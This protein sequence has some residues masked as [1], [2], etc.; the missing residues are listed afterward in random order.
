ME[1]SVGEII[2]I[3]SSKRTRS[4]GSKLCYH[5]DF[6]PGFRSVFFTMNYRSRM[7]KCNVYKVLSYFD[8]GGL[9]FSRMMLLIPPFLSKIVTT[10]HQKERE[11]LNNICKQSAIKQ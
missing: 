10:N 1:R 9:L 7:F 5:G 6:K 2:T 8:R 4:R 3:T 11:T